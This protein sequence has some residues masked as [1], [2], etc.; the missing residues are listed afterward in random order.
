MFKAYYISNWDGRTFSLF[1]EQ[2]RVLWTRLPVACYWIKTTRH[3]C[4]LEL[5]R[6]IFIGYILSRLSA[7][8]FLDIS[9][10]Q[11]ITKAFRHLPTL[12][13]KVETFLLE[14]TWKTHAGVLSNSGHY[15]LNSSHLKF[16]RD[17]W[18]QV[19]RYCLWQGIIL[20]RYKCAILAQTQFFNSQK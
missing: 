17:I 13:R 18:L 11:N 19:T 3:I 10:G 4:R 16:Q 12:G 8:S 2:R 14:F 1:Y 7:K 6:K 9:E 5:I 20:H 15:I